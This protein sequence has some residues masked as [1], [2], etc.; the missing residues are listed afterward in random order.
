MATVKRSALVMHSVSDMYHLINDVLSYPKFLPGCADSKVLHH[1]QESMQASL[2]VK[3]AGMTKWFTTQNRLEKDNKVNM[4]LVD[5]PFKRL[6]GFWE[7]VPLSDEAC[8]VIL[9]L[10]YEFSNN[11]I[12]LA[13]GRAFNNLTHNMVSAFTTRA[14]EVYG[15]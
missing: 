8:K 15:T 7:L 5:G 6:K 3:K 1:D 2:M 14:K 13:F 4:E 10:E 9:E 12:E 11:M